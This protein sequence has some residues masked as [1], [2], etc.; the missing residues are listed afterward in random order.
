MKIGAK[1]KERKEAP[2]R[3]ETDLYGIDVSLMERSIRNTEPKTVRVN[4]HALRNMTL[5]AKGV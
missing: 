5:L 4:H 3:K 1:V 2:V